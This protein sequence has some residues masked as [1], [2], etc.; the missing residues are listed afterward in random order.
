MKKTVI[1]SV[2]ILSLFEACAVFKEQSSD[3]TATKPEK[4]IT[5][6]VY[7]TGGYGQKGK[8]ENYLKQFQKIIENADQNA[9]VLF[10]GDAV[11]SQTR[12]SLS[13]PKMLQEQ[14]GSVGDFKGSTY[15][16]PGDYE[17]KYKDTRK[18]KTVQSLIKNTADKSVRY[19][20]ENGGPLA[21]VSINE[22][23]EI[24]FI[25]SQ[26]YISNWDDVK[27]INENSPDIKTRRRFLEELE[28]MIR[29]AAF[30]NV[31][32]AMHHPIFTNGKHGGKFSFNDYLHPFPVIGFGDKAVRKLG[33]SNPQDIAYSRYR[34]LTSF[35]A[36]LAKLSGNVTIVSGHEANLQYLEGGGI[37]Q[38]ISGSLSASEATKLSKGIITAPGGKLSYRG[39]Y[40]SSENGYAR[41][42]Y[43]QDGSS[44]VEFHSFENNQLLYRHA[45]TAPLPV[46]EK[47]KSADLI[48]TSFAATSK[49]QILTDEET[50]KSGLYKV[51][52][53]DHY[54][55]YYATPVN[56]NTALLDTLHGGL[57]IMKEGGGHQS[58]SLRLENQQGQQYVM[59][60]LRKDALKFLRFKLKGI[61]FDQNAYDDTYAENMVSDFFTTA[62]PYAQLAVSDI[63]EAARINHSDTKLYYF[64]KQA[65]F[66]DL[67]DKYGDGLYF[68]EE[69]PSKGQKD[70]KGFQYSSTDNKGPIIDFAG[71][72][73]VLE[74]LR[75]S[76]KY[77]IDKRQYI[78]SRIFDM[79][80]GDW[81]RHEDQWRWALR[82]TGNKTGIYAPIPRDRDA[83][84][85]KF[86]GVG[87][88]V[89]KQIVPETRFWQTYDEDLQNVKWFNSEA[90]NLDKI[91][92]SQFDESIWIE[93]A[94]SIQKGI[95]DAVI[96]KAFLKLPLEMQ[97]QSLE[98]IKNKLK[99]RLKNI[100][101]IAEEYAGFINKKVIVYGTDKKDIFHITRQSQGNTTIEI[102]TEKNSTVPYYS[103]K[104][105]SD[106]SCE[107]WIYGLNGD[108]DFIVEGEGDHEALVRMIGGYG[109]DHYTIHNNTKA[110][111][112][113]Y[114][115]EKSIIDAEKP[116]KK[117]FS[118]LYETNNL[119][120]RY[121]LPNNN[122]LL[123][124]L[125][126]ATDDG[127]FLG[128]KDK[129]IYN[130]FNGNPHKQIHQIFANYYFT[131]QSAEAGYSGTF[132]N[133]FPHVNLL[134]EAYF[135]GAKFSNNFFGYGNETVK[136]ITVFVPT[137][138]NIFCLL[139]KRIR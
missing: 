132:F 111:I 37:H 118:S 85:S 18:S 82:E 133:I 78:R 16:I 76:E 139:G 110:R 60:S 91:F 89:V 137:L 119:H 109:T 47:K 5:H 23:L 127:F 11:S 59:R 33:G 7:L 96:D 62:H 135:S 73:E 108:D 71:T 58:Q 61:A 136:F 56:V 46:I 15:F 131:Y 103:A 28:S 24:I 54:R 69:R 27:Y 2:F 80:L 53:G 26:W 97:D 122:V 128:I 49:A 99:G 95:T 4:K 34:E 77:S 106:Q 83:A 65:Q 88:A 75:N 105:N 40:N 36:T 22:D 8:G 93:E 10:L 121:F 117:Q 126:F 13:D 129:Y 101:K 112:Y 125:G 41:L 74:K 114:D 30:K 124:A 63:A 57:T 107:I 25:D 3:E 102:F 45:L 21:K 90:Y 138:R 115:Y 51:L 17:W 104:I 38:I 116:S 134:A 44:D 72:T 66:G 6:S 120:F 67:N 12:D 70:F 130:D 35:V 87:L 29:D 64:P 31:I 81:D 68:I 14:L 92:V 79:L 86:D 50:S 100:D 55:K 20:P 9:T 19:L 52:W 113:D 39:I 42:N 94:K 32:I 48:A 123:P 84:F 98:N 1:L 43:Y